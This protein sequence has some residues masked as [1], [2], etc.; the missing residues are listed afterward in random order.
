MD[1]YDFIVVGGGIAG[2]SAGF[3]LAVH[4]SVLLIERESQFGYHSTGRSAAIYMQTRGCAIVQAL[5]TGSKAFFLNPPEGFSERPLLSPRGALV[6]GR[7]DQTADL[8]RAAQEW[9]CFVSGV[10]R[11]NAN[12]AR[13]IVPVLRGDYVAGAVLDPEAMD[14]DVHALHYG[15]LRRLRRRGGTILAGADLRNLEYAQDTW[16]AETAAGKFRASVIINAAGAWCDKVA[17]LAAAK[18][19]N[20]APKRRT[21]LIFDPPAGVDVANWPFVV[22]IGETFYFKPDAGKVLAS[23]ADETPMEP[24]DVYP[25]DLDVAIAVDCI[26]TA[27]RL[28]IKR[29]KRKWAGLRSFVADECPVVGYDPKVPGFF[30]LAG[31]GGSGIKTSPS[32]GRLCASL[33]VGHGI[34]SD[35]IDLGIT[36]AAISPAR[37]AHS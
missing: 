22:D 14:I 33:A 7:G 8:D 37:F 19:V 31:Q 2:A 27:A 35:L 12:Q 25:E 28:P 6:I 4:G 29:I 21:A 5:T 16:T 34:P 30:W 24:C 13:D 1:R 18:P 32:M 26:Q 9:S 11:L 10:R 23:P 3:E 15:F 17:S 20:L 36:Q